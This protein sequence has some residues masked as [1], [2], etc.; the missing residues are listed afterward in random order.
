MVV[1][2]QAW[3]SDWGMW[4]LRR[5]PEVTESNPAMAREEKFRVLGH[6]WFSATLSP[7]VCLYHLRWKHHM[8]LSC[9]SNWRI[10]PQ[11]G[12]DTGP[13]AVYMRPLLA[14]DSIHFLLLSPLPP[15][16]GPNSGW[17]RFGYSEPHFRW[18]WERG[19]SALSSS[20]PL[21][22]LSFFRWRWF[23]G[24]SL[25]QIIKPQWEDFKGKRQCN[26]HQRGPLPERE[27]SGR[28]DNVS[29]LSSPLTIGQC[30]CW[31]CVMFWLEWEGGADVPGG[32]TSYIL[33]ASLE[34][35]PI[36]LLRDSL[37]DATPESWKL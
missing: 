9:Q 22:A 31:H 2:G 29:S 4:E 32:A 11:K 23:L 5:D 17:L 30:L 24:Q 16:S 20:L 15:V 36:S 18:A 25:T 34:F 19:S 12:A 3:V 35:S 14:W 8:S 33:N 21:L 7:S 28:E 37:D 26:C 6:M 13:H 1:P 27:A 10:L